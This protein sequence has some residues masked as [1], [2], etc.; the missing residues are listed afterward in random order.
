VDLALV[1]QGTA[2][3]SDASVVGLKLEL[4]KLFGQASAANLSSPRL[5]W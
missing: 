3:V 5:R 4:K 2:R 1:G